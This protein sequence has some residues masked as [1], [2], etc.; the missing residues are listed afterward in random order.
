MLVKKKNFQSTLVYQVFPA[1]VLLKISEH[2][3]QKLRSANEAGYILHDRD[4]RQWAL[5]AYK[6][7]GDN[8]MVFKASQRKYI[9]LKN[10]IV[11][12]QEK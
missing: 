10:L 7:L 1:R 8:S 5:K 3:I 11:L 4:L 6:E 12:F 9:I 2:I